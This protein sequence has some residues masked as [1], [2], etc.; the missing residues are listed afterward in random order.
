[1]EKEYVC[2]GMTG[3]N[4]YLKNKCGEKAKIEG[5]KGNTVSIKKVKLLNYGE[6]IKLRFK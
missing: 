5:R 2:G 6:G 1:M 3:K 4:V